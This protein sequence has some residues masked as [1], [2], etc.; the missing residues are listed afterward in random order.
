[1]SEVPAFKSNS[2]RTKIKVI[3]FGDTGCRIVDKML[4]EPIRDV[5]FV[6]VE[7]KAHPRKTIESAACIRMDLEHGDEIVRIISESDI[8]LIIA[9]MVDCPIRAATMLAEIAKKSEIITIALVTTPFRFEGNDRSTAAKEATT[10]LLRE[11]DSLFIIHNDRLLGASAQKKSAETAFWLSDE[12]FQRAVRAIVEVATVNGPVQLEV[13]EFEAVLKN[14]GLAWM[15]FGKGTGYNGASDAANMALVSPVLGGTS[16]N[17]TKA[18]LFK[19]VG[20]ASLTLYEVNQAAEIIKQAV[21]PDA[22]IIFGVDR[23]PTIENEARVTLI[24]TGS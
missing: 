1:M 19:I 12:V 24:G 10:R 2:Y 18:V 16:I 15:S 8:V 9:G 11:V 13:N 3:G 7:V 20:G 14:A 23:D 5:E 6:A 21:D 4:P 22:N 17:S